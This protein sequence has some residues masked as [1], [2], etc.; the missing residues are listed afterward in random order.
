MH[1][2]GLT[3]AERISGASEN[4][5]LFLVSS[6]CDLN[7]FIGALPQSLRA[8][9]FVYYF[10]ENQLTYPRSERDTDIR[11]KRDLHYGFIQI[12]SAHAADEV[13]F[14]TALH[15]D[16]FLEAAENYLRKMPDHRLGGV[17]ASIRKKSSAVHL[18]LDLEGLRRM[19]GAQ[20]RKNTLPLLLWN[21]RWEY[22]KEPDVFFESLFG[23]SAAGYDFELAVLGESFGEHPP[24]F[25]EARHRLAK[26][27]VHWGFCES[28]TEYAG[29]LKRAHL[30]PVTAVHD[31][32]GISVVE[33]AAC[34]VRPLLPRGLVYEEHFADD[35]LFYE[36]GKFYEAITALLS[37]DGWREPYGQADLDRYDWKAMA[38]VYDLGFARLAGQSG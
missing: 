28:R 36:R 19:A 16:Q 4:P 37:S 1:G 21:H 10:H 8:K 2:G 31:F 23:L 24:I 17:I 14:N 6:M 32:F 34:G 27:I 11:F 29:W 7:V 22:D 25:A 20:L 12:A 3:L 30:L 9:P 26:H 18:G 33:A 35:A 38:P 15:R 13:W 5:D